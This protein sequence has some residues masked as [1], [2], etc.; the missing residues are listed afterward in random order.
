MDAIASNAA[1]IVID[2]Q[3]GFKDP[4]WGRRDNPDFEANVETL[5]T[6]WQRT[7][8]PIVLVRHNS[9][10]PGSP[11][12][13]GQRGNDLQPLVADLTADLAVGKSAHSSFIGDP[14]LHG[15]LT[16]QGIREIVVCGIQTNRCCETTARVG[17]DLGY[18]VLFAIDATHTFDEVG[19]DGS[20]VSADEFAR[21]TAAN[22]HDNFATVTT[23]AA[24]AHAIA[25]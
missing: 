18:R 23:T 16:A 8:R 19:P 20:A 15:W 21:I 12:R 4:S 2:V 6:G 22:L 24:I 9:R 5:V 3:E 1:L 25:K 11:L 14:D 17:G 10:Q 13:P 7:S